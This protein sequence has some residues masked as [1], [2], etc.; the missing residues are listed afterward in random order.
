MSIIAIIQVAWYCYFFRKAC[1]NNA[2]YTSSN[3]N[4]KLYDKEVGQPLGRMIWISFVILAVV[5]FSVGTF[6]L[7]RLR[8]YFKCFFKDF[9]RSLWIANILLTLPLTFRAV[10][11]FARH[12]D[13]WAHYW[14][15]VNYY[16]LAGYNMT[17][18]TFCTLI[19]IVT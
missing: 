12:N 8:L 3:E 17:I 11:D 6:M 2:F 1:V 14:F 7:R 5:L 16:R 4:F 9:G 15:E 18:I 10:F 19:P 13:D